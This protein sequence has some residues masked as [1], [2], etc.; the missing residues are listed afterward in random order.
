ME[1]FGVSQVTGI[2][3]PQL[4]LISKGLI[5]YF[6]SNEEYINLEVVKQGQTITVFNETEIL[7]L[8]DVKKLI[9]TDYKIWFGSLLYILIYAVIVL[10]WRKKGGWRE[11]AGVFF[12]GSLLTIL[13]MVFMGVAVLIGFDTIFWDFHVISF[14]NDFWLLD[15]SRDYLI[16]LFPEGFWYDSFLLV[17]GMTGAMAIIAAVVCGRWLWVKRKEAIIKG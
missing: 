6:N 2:E 8:R 17:A 10:M 13:L 4:R 14:N 7:H 11:I 3:E 1:R 9:W 5:H 15:P 16:M 12:S